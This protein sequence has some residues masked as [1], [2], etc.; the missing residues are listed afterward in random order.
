MVIEEFSH[1]KEFLQLPGEE[2]KMIY[3]IEIDS[4]SDN[5]IVYVDIVDCL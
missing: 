4:E 3:N 2:I 1:M 5:N